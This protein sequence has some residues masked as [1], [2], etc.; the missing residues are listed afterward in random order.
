MSV[1]VPDCLQ[2]GEDSKTSSPV[3]F[4]PDARMQAMRSEVLGFERPPKPFENPKK[5][6]TIITTTVKTPETH[7]NIPKTNQ[8]QQH[9]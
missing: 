9:M 5:P 2:P 3:T 4:N 7:Y 8:Q 1:E 6:K